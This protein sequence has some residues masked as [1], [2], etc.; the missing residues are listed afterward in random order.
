MKKK[1]G[2][3]DCLYDSTFIKCLEQAIHEKT[4][5]SGQMQAGLCEF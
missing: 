1:L 5:H 3:E 2:T 4:Q